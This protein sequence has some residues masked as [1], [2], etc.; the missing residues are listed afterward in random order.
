MRRGEEQR[1]AELGRKTGRGGGGGHPWVKMLG[2]AP[3]S[4][5]GLGPVT[6]PLGDNIRTHPKLS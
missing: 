3:H 2:S 4:L 6:E 5:S 1:K